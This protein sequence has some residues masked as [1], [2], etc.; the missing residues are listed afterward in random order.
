MRI[1]IVTIFPGMFSGVFEFGMIR[2]ACR[3]GLLRVR[4]VDLRDFT[5]DRHRT[6][7]D[8][9][10]G[11]GEGMV[12]KPEPIYRAVEVCRQPADQN[13][14]VV[15]LTPQGERF[16]QPLA[17]ELASKDHLILICGRYEGVDNRIAEHVADREVSIGDFVVSGGEVAAMLLVDAVSRLIPGVVGNASSVLEESFM[18]GLLDYPQYTRP[19]EFRGWKVPDVLLSGDHLEIR[20]WREEQALRL[21]KKRRPD[22]LFE[23]REGS[24]AGSPVVREGREG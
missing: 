9:P 4:T 18:T 3:R 23:S 1:D 22:L 2:Q 17:T 7:D 11:G 15:L 20:R 8:R 6:V 16:E 24:T 5:D 13:V 12:M 10:F 21:T 14:S 19:A